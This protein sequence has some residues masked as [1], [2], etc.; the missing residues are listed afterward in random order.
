MSDRHICIVDDDKDDIFLMS[1]SLKRLESKTAMRFRV[2][3]F[4]NGQDAFD[5]FSTVEKHDT[6]LPDCISLDIN[7]PGIDGMELLRRLREM[8]HLA[9]V[10]IYI[11]STTANIKTR[12][13]AL[14]YGANGAFA[15]PETIAD[16]Q[17][18]QRELLAIPE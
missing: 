10:P 5:Y 13:Q 15:K 4:Y 6:D 9:R 12:R 17:A 11:V 7:M 3:A 16:M 8:N 18:M 2:S 1:T 14:S